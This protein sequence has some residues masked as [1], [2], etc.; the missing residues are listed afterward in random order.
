MLGILLGMG[1]FAIC[2]TI[3]I[4]AGNR[5]TTSLR[6]WAQFHEFNTICT[7]KIPTYKTSVTDCLNEIHLGDFSKVAARIW[8]GEEID[9]LPEFLTAEEVEF[10]SSYFYKIRT[11]DFQ[12]LSLLFSEADRYAEQKENKAREVSEKN[13]KFCKKLGVLAGIASFIFVV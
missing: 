12:S 1:L 9:S 11:S 10:L 2:A 13:E 3:G 8:G 6:F 4:R 7:I 5:Y